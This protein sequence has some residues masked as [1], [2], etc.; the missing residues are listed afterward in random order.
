M[1]SGELRERSTE[2]SFAH[3]QAQQLQL[4]DV[5]SFFTLCDTFNIFRYPNTETYS[6]IF[7]TT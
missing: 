4:Q 5:V 1:K 2:E 6:E 3:L 7:T